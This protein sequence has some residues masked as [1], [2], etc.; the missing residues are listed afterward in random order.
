VLTL[1][2]ALQEGYDREKQEFVTLNGFDLKLEHS[3]VSL[4]KWESH[5]KKPFLTDKPK[6][7]EETLWYVKAMILN[8]EVPP[9]LFSRLKEHHAEAINN[10]IQDPMSATWFA[11]TVD[12][13]KNTEVITAEIIYYWMIEFRIPTEFQYWHLER[14][15]TLIK[16]CNEKSKPPKKMSPR[17]AQQ[18]QRELN[19][20]RRAQLGTAG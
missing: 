11:E 1:N 17:E 10:Y 2:V 19:E 3:L 5:F 7:E 13:R 15:L 16:V 20:R 12:R 4:S 6:T 14:L 18:R 8:E 9:E